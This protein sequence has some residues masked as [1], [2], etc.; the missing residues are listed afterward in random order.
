MRDPN[1]ASPHEAAPEFLTLPK[2]Q[3]E[4]LG[5]L[6]CRLRPLSLVM[7]YDEATPGNEH[8][9]LLSP[10]VPEGA[11]RPRQNTMGLRIL[12]IET[13]RTLSKGLYPPQ[14]LRSVRVWAACL[15]HPTALR[16]NASVNATCHLAPVAVMTR[17]A[18]VGSIS[19][20]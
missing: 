9:R 13:W 6:L 15:P 16:A 7:I 10:V 12:S 1:L 4:T 20:V 8:N 3:G 17:R 11:R 2:S 14:W 19:R 5:V 18:S